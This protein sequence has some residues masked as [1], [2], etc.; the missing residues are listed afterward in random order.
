MSMKAKGHMR[1]AF[2]LSVMYH[3]I[4]MRRIRPLLGVFLLFRLAAATVP[5]PREH[6]GFTPGDD[7]KLMDYGQLIAY[8]QKLEK[9]SDRIRLQEFGKTSMGKPMYVAFISAP[10]NLKRLK[11]YQEINRKLALGVPDA[12]EAHRLAQQGKAVVWIDS[13]L[14]ATEVAPAQQAPELAYKMLT[15]ESEETRRI[16]QNVILVQIPC[17]NPDG[18]DWVVNWYRQNVG[19]PY[20]LA[21]LP[22]LWHKYAGHDN[23]RDWYML[24]LPET[25]NVSRLL[26]QEWF[27]NILYNQHQAPPFPARIFVPPYAE[28]LNPNIPAPVME[29]INLIGSAMSERFA[30]E[31]KPGIIS[32]W[33]YDAWWN[34]GLRSVPAFHN[35]HGILTEVAGVTYATPKIY[36]ASELPDRFGNGNPTKEP[37]IF[38]Q[39]PWMGGKWGVREA[40]DYMLTADWAILELASARTEHFLFKEYAMARANM[41]SAQKPYAYVVPA[42]QWDASAAREML[43]RLSAA[44]VR[45]ERASAEFQAAGKSYPEGTYVLRTRQ[46]FRG[47]LVDLMEPQKYPELKTGQTGPT[48]RPYDI[49]GW[50][51]P[52]QM[53]VQMDR[54]EEAFEAKLVDAAA[55]P[56]KQTLDHREDA[57]YAATI[58]L[59]KRGERVGWAADGKIVTGDAPAAWVLK[60]PRVAIYEPWT[61]NMDAGWTEWLMDYYRVP[62]TVI[63]NDDFKKGDLKARFDTIVLASQS[64]ASILHGTRAGEGAGGGRQDFG[65]LKPVQRPEYSGGIESSGMYEL[66]KFVQSGGTLVALDAATEL[67]IQQ[68]SIGVR[69]LLRAAPEGRDAE[70][71]SNGY[72]CPGSLLRITVDTSNPIAF[73]M[74]KD[75]IAFSS[76]GQAFDIALLPEYNKGNQEVRPVAKY[77]SSNLLASGWISGERAVLGKTILME[78]RHGQGRIVLFGFRPQHRGQTFGTFK[79]LLNTVYLGSAQKM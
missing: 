57:S 7:Y 20:E 25:Q 14:H 70:V 75:A 4:D 64:A 45:V 52:M 33:G 68:Y 69:A 49:A 47:Y 73:G 11:E 32:Y 16:R 12:A 74:P 29:G 41:E 21:P 38:Y 55:I 17:I 78:A 56:A 71:P 34:G 18:L 62:Y 5:T 53:G 31:N 59:L 77:A 44:G 22:Y 27:P 13:G 3:F 10:E 39:R 76:G 48:K 19:T 42:E 26:F 30:R 1:R 6:L 65:D 28:P 24:N 35:M 60:T 58:D 50:T 54:V 63:H 43:Q 2:R 15:D 40:I 67:P 8:F 46:P 72:Y 61:A 9:A 36:K 51:L 66:D 79:F 23:N 37:T